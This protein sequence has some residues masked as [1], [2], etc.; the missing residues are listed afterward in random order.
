M[1]KSV[2]ILSVLLAATAAQARNTDHVLPVEVA[3]QSEVGRER[4]LEMPFYFAGQ[5][6]PAVVEEISVQRSNRSTRGVFRSDESSCEIA[7][8]S[9]LRALQARAQQDGADAIIDIRSVTKSQ[10]LESATEYRCVAGATVV[11][12]GLEG[13]LVRAKTVK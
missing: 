1:R 6:H 11:H 5:D 9:A 13:T 10:P 4:L 3:V 8:L 2:V 7:F 12:V